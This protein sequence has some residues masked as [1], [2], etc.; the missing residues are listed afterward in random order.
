MASYEKDP[1]RLSQSCQPNKTI[2]VFHLP[3]RWKRFLRVV[4]IAVSIIP[5]YY[6]VDAITTLYPVETISEFAS[7]LELPS[8]IFLMYLRDTIQGL[9]TRTLHIV[10]AGTLKCKDIKPAPCTITLGE[11]FFHMPIMIQCAWDLMDKDL[12]F[13]WEKG[14]GAC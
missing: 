9:G 14:H 10:I 1:G 11:L 12:D 7:K 6:T 13:R 4:F 8:T 2:L 3:C 5:T